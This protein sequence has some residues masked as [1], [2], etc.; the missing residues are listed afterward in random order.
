L[1][2][3]LR[4]GVGTS[5]SLDCLPTN[6]GLALIQHCAREKDL[7][8]DDS[9]SQMIYQKTGGLP[10]AITYV[11]GQMAVYG[12]TLDVVSTQL[13]QTDNDFAGYCF[14]ES[15]HK[16]KGQL[17]YSLLLILG[18]FEQSAPT[19]AIAYIAGEKATS[20]VIQ[21]GLATLHRLSLVNLVQEYYDLHPL[22]RSYICTELSMN[23]QFEQESQ[24]RWVDWY[25]NFLAPYGEKTWRDWQE[26]AAL[27]REWENIRKV[28]EWC[29]EQDRYAEFKQLWQS[30]KGYTQS[31][32][33][34][35]ERLS[36][37][38]WLATAATQREDWVTLAD[39]NYHTSRTL[40]L[41]NQPDQTEKAI[42]LSQQSWNLASDPELQVDLTIHIAALYA[43]QHQLQQALQWLD[44]GESLLQQCLSATP[45]FYQQVDIDYYKA[46]IHLKTKEYEQAKELYLSAL[47]KAELLNWER[48]V[49]Y[50][51]GWLSV[52]Q[53][54]QGNLNDAEQQLGW[55]LLQAKQA[56]DKRCLS[57][58][59]KYLAILS[60]KCGK[61]SAT[62]HWAK[63]AKDGFSQLH[64]EHQAIEIP[65][66]PNP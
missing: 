58:C 45:L 36:W 6:E 63:L 48:A 37:L 26:C 19:E 57:F 12:V 7:Q 47:T 32:G 5:I 44:Q 3:R 25:L 52:I 28:V 21:Q 11:V 51:K 23:A 41:F 33:H 54:A 46:E 40:C 61:I 20:R 59:Y 27:E 29:R 66:F 56:N 9:Q 13:T 60:Q 42:A 55:V 62:Q 17:A 18:L 16:I 49:V 35:H 10:L 39:A 64:M 22:T 15:I 24:K 30:L 31:Y 65:H 43:Q 2:S 14:V 53:I 34:W 8:I 4:L 38:D 1:T 50:I